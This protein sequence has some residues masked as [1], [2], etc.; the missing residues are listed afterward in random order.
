MSDSR[1]RHGRSCQYRGVRYSDRSFC[2]LNSRDGMARDSVQERH[3]STWTSKRARCRK[4]A[5]LLATV[6]GRSA[7]NTNYRDIRIRESVE[8]T[9]YGGRLPVPMPVWI[10]MLANSQV[11]CTINRSLTDCVRI[12]EIIASTFSLLSWY[13]QFSP[14]SIYTIYTSQRNLFR[15]EKCC[16]IIVN[17]R[18]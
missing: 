14:F 17:D 4:A 18:V 16:F 15:E 8:P 11:Q 5:Y 3:V 12:C 2:K 7:F 6:I 10:S 9:I 1:L 13:E